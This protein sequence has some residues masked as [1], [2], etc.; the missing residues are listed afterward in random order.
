MNEYG[1]SQ[2]SKEIS[3]P[4]SNNILDLI[5]TNNPSSVSHVYCTPGMS[6]HNAVIC[7]LNI[8]PQYKRQPK[9]TI[10][11]Y[12]KANWD[13]IRTETK[14][15]SELYFE[16]NPDIYTVEGNCLF[17]QT[18]IENLIQTLVP[19]RLSKSKFHFPWITKHVRRQM[20]SRDMLYA[21]A[22]KSKS[23]HDW[24]RFKDAR[25][26]V[27]QNIRQSHRT[28][29]SEIVAASLNDSPKSFWS[30]ISALHRED[31]GIST[32]RTSSGLPATCAKANVVNEQFQSVFTGEDMQNLPSCKKLF[33]D[34]T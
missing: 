15:L 20:K 18:S 29:I 30:Y 10:F 19:S 12:N 4:A 26:K 17:I 21:K 1:L 22:I 32:L 2:H 13:D 8:L 7:V 11:M 3:R 16:R 28:Y 25:S 14:H 27:K 9:R 23:P 5:L 34:M 31:T 6:D 33:P 24:K